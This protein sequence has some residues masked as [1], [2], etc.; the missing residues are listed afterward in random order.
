MAAK[1]KTVKRAR[2][3]ANLHAHCP[4]ELHGASFELTSA[5]LNL[6]NSREAVRLLQQLKPSPPLAPPAPGVEPATVFA[7]NLARQLCGGFDPTPA[8]VAAIIPRV[9][10]RDDAIVTALKGGE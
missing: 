2:K 8:M 1:T 7:E 10:M 4:P 3:P 6:A 9:R 5:H